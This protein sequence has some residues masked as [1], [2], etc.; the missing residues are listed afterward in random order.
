MPVILD[1]VD[2]NNATDKDAVAA[3]AVA[4]TPKFFSSELTGSGK[5]TGLLN[6]NYKA[7]D[8]LGAPMASYGPLNAKRRISQNGVTTTVIPVSPLPTNLLR[9]VDYSFSLPVPHSSQCFEITT[10]AKGPSQSPMFTKDT[11]LLFDMHPQAAVI[12]EDGSGDKL[13]RNLVVQYRMELFILDGAKATPS[14]RVARVRGN[15][16]P[17]E[18][19]FLDWSNS[20][21][22][23]A[24]T[25]VNE[26]LDRYGFEVA[27]ADEFTVWLN[28]YSVHNA[29]VQA[30]EAW[31]SD[32]IA[33]VYTTYLDDF[34]TAVH[35][36]AQTTEHLNNIATALRYL[37]NYNVSLSAYRLIHQKL[38]AL[39]PQD[40]A[41]VM[42]KQNL[43]L[44]IN[45]TLNHLELIKNQLVT[46][47]VPATAASIPGMSL[48]QIAAATTH[49]PLVLTQAGAGTGKSTTI[50]KRI[51][52]LTACGVN[53]QDVTV[54][55][56]TNAAADNITARNPNVGSMTIAR[57]IHDIYSLNHPTHA[58]SNLDTVRNSLEIFFPGDPAAQ[59]LHNLLWK[60]TKNE[61]HAFTDLN[62]YIERHFDDVMRLLDGI[63]QTTLELEI[64]I[65]YQR[66]ETM[67]EPAHV[68]CKYLIIDEVQDNSIFEFIYLLKYVSKHMSSLFIVGDASQTLFEFRAANPRALNTLESSGVFATFM[69]TT[70]YRS[71]QEILD[72]ANV[73]LGKLETNLSGMQ[74][75]ANSLAS[76]SAASFQDKVAVTHRLTRSQKEFRE[77]LPGI[78]LTTVL[79][80]YVD[81][82]LAAGEQVAFLARSRAEVMIMQE[83]LATAYPNKMIA[84]LTSDKTFTS[85]V[86]SRYIKRY[87]DEVLQV[88]PSKAAF[89]VCQGI[90]D[91]MNSLVS[92][93][94]KADAVIRRT[95]SNWWTENNTVVTAW[96]TQHQAGALSTQ[97]F[98]AQLRTNLLDFEISKNSI[99]TRLKS[100]RNAERK[101]ANLAARPDMFV[102]TIH[103][104]KGLEFDHVVVLYH[105]ENDMSQEMRRLFYVAFTR[106]MKSEFILAHGKLKNPAIMA[107]YATHVARLEERDKA[108]L[109]RQLGIDP[110]LLSDDGDDDF[111]VEF[112]PDN[113]VAQPAG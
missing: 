102:S 14:E 66:I 71:N 37:E 74:L 36:N 30:A 31:S 22:K 52:Y 25:T 51:D 23:D 62:S 20:P 99:A 93:P 64:V 12:V 80:E 21:V 40:I 86:I 38:E 50:M 10:R 3:Y 39:F 63:G 32:D 97:D 9:N 1:D 29:F 70:N 18:A 59:T 84:N 57:M 98:F 13:V 5:S 82:K 72:F 88:P 113:E 8:R 83:A 53:S 48:Q 95:V 109:A 65:C 56:F 58:L 92:N 76:P 108:E 79:P 44:L 49:E 60:V 2:L 4:V 45:H 42:S 17:D 103:G 26:T 73:A 94:S 46:P 100:Q 55:S 27:N 43:N 7:I 15:Y 105:D 16:F 110:A 91:N 68:Q 101:Q 112:D 47:P 81:A 11:R 67:V 75:Q 106:A 90:L 85:D 104:A 54:L 6:A 19:V 24:L 96:V 111:D 41:E 69:L 61:T 35:A 107:D 87:W 34:V 77:N 28:G 89:V 33:H 78:L